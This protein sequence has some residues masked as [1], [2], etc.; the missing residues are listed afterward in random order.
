MASQ[1]AHQFLALSDAYGL[2]YLASA[3][4]AGAVDTLGQVCGLTH[5][6]NL[7]YGKRQF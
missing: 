3:T 1:V 5:F 7:V 2:S 6:D 4:A